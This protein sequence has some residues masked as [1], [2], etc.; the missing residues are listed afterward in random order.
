MTE[1]PNTGSGPVKSVVAA[2][3]AKLSAISFP[4]MLLPR[5]AGFHKSRT[6]FWTDKLC[7]FVMVSQTNPDVVLAVEIAFN[8][9][10][11]SEQ[12]VID[13]LTL[14]DSSTAHIKTA[15]TSAW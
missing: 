15:Y 14:L 8:A 2:C 9:A 13:L 11:L 12:I 4:S 5:M 6:Q 3:F 7:I 1:S 10:R